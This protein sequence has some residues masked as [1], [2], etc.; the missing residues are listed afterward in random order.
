[1]ANLNLSGTLNV[2]RLFTNPSLCLPHATV[3]TFADLPIPLKFPQPNIPKEKE[4]PPSEILAVVLDK[5]NCFAVPNTTA[6]HPPYT[7]IF[8]AL[9]T[10]YPG[11]RLLIVSNSAGTTAD[12]GFVEAEA[13]ERETGVTVLR[14]AT[15]KPG[16]RTEIMEYFRSRPETGVS[17]PD[18]VAVVGDRLFTDVVL[19]N[20][21]GAR[22]VWVRDGVVEDRGLV[23]SMDFIFVSSADCRENETT[24]WLTLGFA[25]CQV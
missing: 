12:P 14:H 15:K 25:V 24:W 19:A 11:P 23:S 4:T 17:R 22:S 20:L 10:A 9:R 21:M 5:D 18:Q 16:C 13:L 6:I 1:M 8:S 2:L 7:P 3:S